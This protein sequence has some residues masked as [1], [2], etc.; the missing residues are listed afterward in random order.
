MP[1]TLLS[2]W[3][4][5]AFGVL[6]CNAVLGLDDR[7]F[8][9]GGTGI[10]ANSGSSGS[11]TAGSAG[12]GSGGSGATSGMSAIGSD[13]GESGSVAMGRS[14]QSGGNDGISGNSSASATGSTSGSDTIGTSTGTG[15]T[16]GGTSVPSTGTSGACAS[17]LLI[18][19]AAVALSVNGGN[20]ASN[21]IDGSLSTR[22]ESAQAID[23]EWIYV[24]FGVPVFIGEVDVLWESACAKNYDIDISNDATTWTVIP[25][26]TIVGNTLAG[27]A[28]ADGMTPK[29]WTKAVVTKPLAAVGRYLRVN[30][31]V[32]CSVYGYSIW[33]MRAYGDTKSSCAP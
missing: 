4:L 25:N 14:A 1:T 7:T 19:L 6:G 9:E 33:E 18:P 5:L 8:V 2:P 11:A 31:T 27:N 16:S 3:P 28:I 15:T 20:V 22:W 21:A 26:G 24:D 10:T 13:V 12:Q 23:P 30:G 29:D 17:N 32:R